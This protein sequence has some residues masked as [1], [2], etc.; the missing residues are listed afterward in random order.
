[1]T[2]LVRLFAWLLALA[3]T[4]ATL[5]PPRFRPHS[6][7]GQDGEHALAFALIGLVFG[8]AYSR[9]RLLTSVAS[10]VVI[11]I[12]E[13]MQLWAPG[14]HARFEDFVVDALAACAGFTVAAGL[15]WARLRLR[16]KYQPI[17]I[18]GREPTGPAFGRPDDRLRERARNP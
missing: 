13:I 3:V 10:V 16:W 14:R 2:T 5:G 9:N 17:V 8:L 11:G 7:L 6:D 18:P 4:F 1:M 12:L 15:D